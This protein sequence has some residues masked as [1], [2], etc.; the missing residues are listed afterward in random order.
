MMT[1][2][3]GLK[4]SKGETAQA[5]GR[6]L[7]SAK[8]R[9]GGSSKKARQEFSAGF[10]LFRQTDQGRVYLL[11]DYGRHWD[12]AKGHLEDGETAWKAAVRELREETAIRKVDRIG[13]FE[14]SMQYLFYSPKKGRV[15]K[16]VT[17]FLGKTTCEDVKLSDE[18]AGYA[19]LGYHDAMKQLTFENAREILAAAEA[20]L[21]Q[22]GA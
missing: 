19:W 9:A 12:Y 4:K 7:K 5:H 11:L 10:I 18:H 1:P 8:K 16:T 3:Q 17:Y 14:K 15:F 20:Y 2:G 6:G 13:H 22:Q 21:S